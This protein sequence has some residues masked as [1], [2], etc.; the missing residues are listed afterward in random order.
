VKRRLRLTGRGDFQRLLAGNRIFAGR[1][2][3][4]FAVRR[5]AHG[6]RIGVSA[7]RNVK[8]AVARNR[9]RRRLREVARTI[10]LAPASPLQ[11][12]GIGYDVVLIARPAAVEAP[13]SA[14]EAEAKVLLGRL[15][16][17]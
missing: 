15:V 4:G 11:Q 14:L 16:S 7:S 9:A 12:R 1:G 13:Y 8:G 5:D 6:S 2:M 10:L 17:E 3:V